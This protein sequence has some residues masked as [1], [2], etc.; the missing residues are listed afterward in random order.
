VRA[1]A[2]FALLIDCSGSMRG[3]KITAAIAAARVFAEALARVGAPFL[4]A[5]F[6]DVTF[7]LAPAGAP[8]A[9]ALDGIASARLEVAGTRPGG[10]N[11]PRHNDD[12]PCLLATAADLRALPAR[13]RVL[14]VLSDG[15]PSG[16]RSDANDLRSAVARLTR[17]GDIDLIGIG[18][19]PQATHVSTYYPRH[20][21][22]ERVDALP[23]ALVRAL[24]SRG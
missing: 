11:V 17:E 7:P 10:N 21:V 3:P 22:V 9:R 24:T 15:A 13:Q 2:A 6:Q 4:V 14:V 20:V 12:G 5:G 23:A 19:G 8:L 1:D 18:I 16:R